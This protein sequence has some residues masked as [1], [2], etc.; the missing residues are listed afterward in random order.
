MAG[1]KELRTRIESIKSTQKITSAMKLVAASRL[2]R[3]QGLIDKS[4]FY[5]NNLVSSA[6]RVYYELR[7]EEAAKGVSYIYPKLLRGTGKNKTC[8]LIVFTSDRG[9]CGGYNSNV[10][11]AAAKRI[12]E[13]TAEGTEVKILCVG[14]KGR[15][16]LKR[17]YAALIVKTLE[18]L[19][20]KGAKYYEATDI[21]QLILEAYDKGEID[22]C[23]VVVS[24]FISAITRQVKTE[25][26][27]PVMIEEFEYNKLN[28]PTNVI[29][30]AFYDYEPDKMELLAGLLP[31]IFKASLFQ[32]IVHSQASEHGA[33]MTSMDN[34]TRN[35]KDMISRLTLKYNRIRQTAITTELTEIISGAEAI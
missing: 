29:N 5:N 19:G 12:E 24:Y 23:E 6:N 34:A 8:L 3:A 16:I 10:A 32:A 15:D 7:Q 30:G 25:P 11:K 26:I 9:L 1:M 28:L 35:A 27:L 4:S 13:L 2:R 17:K 14:K 21:A 20:K 22:R 31:L 33:R 18:G